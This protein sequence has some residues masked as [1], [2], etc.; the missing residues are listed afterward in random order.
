MPGDLPAKSLR[1][2]DLGYF[3]LERFQSLSEQQIYW[4]SRFKTGTLVWD[5]EGVRWNL[6][7]LLATQTTA[8]VDLPVR[9]GQAGT[10]ACRLLAVRAPQEVVDQRRRRLYAEARRRGTTPSPASLALAAWTILITNVPAD[11]LT[12]QEA[13]VVARTRWQ[14]ELLFKL[15]KCHGRIDV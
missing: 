2:I 1:L 6:P 4:L 8:V 13:L 12:V 7:D 9:L 3:R 5:V 11:L 15:W 14:I 10:L